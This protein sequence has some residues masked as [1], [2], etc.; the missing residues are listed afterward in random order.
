M[1]G[2]DAGSD[3][4]ISLNDFAPS[5]P[6]APD[7]PYPSPFYPHLSSCTSTEAFHAAFG[8]LYAPSTQGHSMPDTSNTSHN[9]PNDALF[10]SQETRDAFFYELDA[11][12]GVHIDFRT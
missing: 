12:R 1:A 10:P 8:G 7:A 4:L 5:A 11:L 9:A 3:A 2:W 6:D